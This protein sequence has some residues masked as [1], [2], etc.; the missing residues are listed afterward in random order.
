MSMQQGNDHGVVTSR[1]GSTAVISP[2]L[3]GHT[4]GARVASSLESLDDDHASPQHGRAGCGS[5]SF[6]RFNRLNFNYRGT[7]SSARPGD[8]ALRPA[9]ASRP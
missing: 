9:L 2:V 8:I 3:A 7:A 5:V 1:C 4:G 6:N